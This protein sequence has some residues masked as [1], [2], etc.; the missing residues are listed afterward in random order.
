MQVDACI[1]F[2][3]FGQGDIEAVWLSVF[4]GYGPA[5]A[6]L[7]GSAFSV[8]GVF[9]RPVLLG[10]CGGCFTKF[11]QLRGLAREVRIGVG[12][13]PHIIKYKVA[14]RRP[15]G[16]FRG[17]GFVRQ[18]FNPDTGDTVQA[19]FI[20]HLILSYFRVFATDE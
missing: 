6:V 5:R 3:R 17:K 1:D 8:D 11:Q 7:A 16:A 9:C 12:V 20:V 13:Y 14:M 4:I 19:G 15:S 10:I 2:Q 18:D